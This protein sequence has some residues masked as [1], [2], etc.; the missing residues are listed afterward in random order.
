MPFGDSEDTAPREDVGV[1]I[2]LFVFPQLLLHL[3]IVG[4]HVAA[5]LAPDAAA[6]IMLEIVGGTIRRGLSEEA[7]VS[8]SLV[9]PAE[10]LLA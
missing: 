4:G 2:G 5:R 10:R 3:K 1:V 6:G 8:V 7:I 9:K